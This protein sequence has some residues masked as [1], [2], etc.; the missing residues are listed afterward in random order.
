MQTA[1][2]YVMCWLWYHLLMLMQSTTIYE[3]RYSRCAGFYLYWFTFAVSLHT[4]LSSCI[5]CVAKKAARWHR[6]QRS[7]G[8]TRG[9]WKELF[10][11]RS[12]QCSKDL[13]RQLNPV[14]LVSRVDP[15]LSFSVVHFHYWLLFGGCLLSIALVC[16][17]ARLNTCSL[18]RSAYRL[19][20]DPVPVH[21][22]RSSESRCVCL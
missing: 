16:G 10:G 9:S 11:W 4:M 3:L 20:F 5:W 13:S 14:R 17:T 21:K 22:V 19:G 6:C 12:F 1:D 15:L 18:A 7:A 8:S 2:G